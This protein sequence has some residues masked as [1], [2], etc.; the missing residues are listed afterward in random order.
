MKRIVFLLPLVVI[1]AFAA[2]LFNGLKNGSGNEIPS[3]LI[4]N[5]MPALPENALEGFEGKTASDIISSNKVTLVNY[6]AS[7][8]GPCRAEHPNLIKLKELGLPII[9]VNYKD[10]PENAIKF[11]NELGNP[12]DTV[13]V[14]D[15]GRVAINWGVSGVPETFFVNNDGDVVYRFFGP[16]TGEKLENEILPFLGTIE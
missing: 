3:T 2:L 16:I 15:T 10:K 6:F 7:W 4:G 1:V 13:L 8:C 5:P 14:D 12:Y 11:M 9:G